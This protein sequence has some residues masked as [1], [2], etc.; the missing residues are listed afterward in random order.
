MFTK[1]A[2]NWVFHNI[3]SL[4]DNHKIWAKKVVLELFELLQIQRDDIN[5]ISLTC[6]IKRQNRKIIGYTVGKN[7]SV[8]KASEIGRKY[9]VSKIEDTWMKLPP[10]PTQV[11]TKPVSPSVAPAPR[12]QKFPPINQWQYGNQ[13]K[14]DKHR[15]RRKIRLRQ[16]DEWCRKRGWGA[17]SR[18]RTCKLCSWVEAVEWGHWQ[19]YQHLHQCHIWT[20]ICHSAESLN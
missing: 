6:T 2:N 4:V 9:M 11:K 18:R 15:H 7:A 14:Q 12:Q 3:I 5:I 8:F 19:G 17:A 13:K 1:H 20:G 10:Q 16:H